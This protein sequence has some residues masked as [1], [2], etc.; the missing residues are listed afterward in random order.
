MCIFKIFLL[1]NKFPKPLQIHI[2]FVFVGGECFTDLFDDGSGVGHYFVIGNIL[3]KGVL[4][5][6]DK[7]LFIE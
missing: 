2:V 4:C 5:I 3:L 1:L 7:M 6:Y